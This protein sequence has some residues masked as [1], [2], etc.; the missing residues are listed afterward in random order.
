MIKNITGTETLILNNFF[1]ALCK[2]GRLDVNQITHYY[3]L[4]EDIIKMI[5]H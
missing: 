2:E 4:K 5:W 1:E 3:L